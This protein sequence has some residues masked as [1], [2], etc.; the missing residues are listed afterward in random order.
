MIR[1]PGLNSLVVNQMFI[2][3]S[4]PPTMNCLVTTALPH[5]FETIPH[6]VFALL[7]HSTYFHLFPRATLPLVSVQGSQVPFL[8][9]R[10]QTKKGIQACT[11]MG[12]DH[13]KIFKGLANMI[14]LGKKLQI[15]CKQFQPQIF[16]SHARHWAEAGDRGEANPEHE[17]PPHDLDEMSLWHSRLFLSASS[18][19]PESSFLKATRF[20]HFLQEVFHDQLRG[21]ITDAQAKRSYSSYFWMPFS[22]LHSMKALKKG[23]TCQLSISVIIKLT[24]PVR[25]QSF[26]RKF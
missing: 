6:A 10:V 5:S 19:S 14:I 16:P 24:L 23:S 15:F 20:T 17:G 8:L 9:H 2:Y 7:F 12:V 11:S 18:S 4:S 1:P 25:F 26:L 21:I 13:N 3:G 22:K